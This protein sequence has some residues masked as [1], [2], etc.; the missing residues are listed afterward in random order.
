MTIA[1]EE[2]VDERIT[3]K[4][5]SPVVPV[6]GSFFVLSCQTERRKE[7]EENNDSFHRLYFLDRN[8]DAVPVRFVALQASNIQKKSGSLTETGL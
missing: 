3:G 8:K 7:C 5:E 6:L 2:L 4:A 1:K